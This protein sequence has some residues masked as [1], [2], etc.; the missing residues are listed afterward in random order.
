MK[1]YGMI[2]MRRLFSR[3][4]F[5]TSRCQK[6][7]I[8][9]ALCLFSSLLVWC[10]IGEV[11]VFKTY[12]IGWKWPTPRPDRP[13][14][15]SKTVT[16]QPRSYHQDKDTHHY[17]P[18]SYKAL[19]ARDRR[20]VRRRKSQTADHYLKIMFISDPHIMCTNNM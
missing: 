7:L 3:Y 19:S 15:A 9:A 16:I 17:V 12:S 18:G 1:L 20:R 2:Y 6:I 10:F 11:L 8:A 4:Y 13:E 14:D 5:F